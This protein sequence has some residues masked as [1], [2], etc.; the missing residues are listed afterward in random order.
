MTDH[1][2]QIKKNPNNFSSTPFT[3]LLHIP[4]TRE[5]FYFIVKD[6]LAYIAI[7]L[8]YITTIKKKNKILMTYFNSSPAA[9]YVLLTL[10]LIICSIIGQYSNHPMTKS[11]QICCCT[12]R[13]HLCRKYLN[14][15][16]LHEEG[17]SS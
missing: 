2:Y 14:N 6:I 8:L 7:S 1:V 12:S 11:F 5:N 9:M 15:L 4:N 3:Q 10:L 17:R 13:S 16:L